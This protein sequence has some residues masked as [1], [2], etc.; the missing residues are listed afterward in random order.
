MVIGGRIKRRIGAHHGELAGETAGE[1]RSQAID[2]RPSVHNPHG[3]ASKIEKWPTLVDHKGKADAWLPKLLARIS[4]AADTIKP[5]IRDAQ[6]GSEAREWARAILDTLERTR[7]KING[8]PYIRDM[9]K[10]LEKEAAVTFQ[11]VPG[12]VRRCGKLPPFGPDKA[13]LDAWKATGAEML[14]TECGDFHKHKDWDRFKKRWEL[15]DIRESEK[16]T[17]ILD[18]IKK[19]MDTLAGARPSKRSH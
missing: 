3:Y 6:G 5:R 14:R 1:I 15:N 8:P 10:L 13:T 11:P 7:R 9:L 18:S 12:W 2:V 19:A 16:A 4:L 17:R